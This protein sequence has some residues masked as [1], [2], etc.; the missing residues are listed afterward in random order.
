MLNTE[1]KHELPA[2]SNCGMGVY[3]LYRLN[4]FQNRDAPTLLFTKVVPKYKVYKDRL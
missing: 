1:Y 4:G 3:E 2:I